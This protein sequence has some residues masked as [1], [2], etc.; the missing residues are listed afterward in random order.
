MSFVPGQ[1]TTGLVRRSAESAA[2]PGRFALPAPAL[3]LLVVRDAMRFQ[4]S[5]D[6]VAPRRTS[7]P[8]LFHH[9]AA[10]HLVDPVIG[11]FHQYG[12]A[13]ALASPAGANSASRRAARLRHFCPVPRISLSAMSVR[14]PRSGSRSHSRR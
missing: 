11:A 3:R 1:S 8:A 5:P 2:S 9:V 14:R 10:D 7:P 4:D 12:W 6:F 13:H